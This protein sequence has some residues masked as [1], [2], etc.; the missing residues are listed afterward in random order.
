MGLRSLFIMPLI[1]ETPTDLIKQGGVKF[2]ILG[3]KVG[4]SDWSWRRTRIA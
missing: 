3:K 4:R 1:S 2:K